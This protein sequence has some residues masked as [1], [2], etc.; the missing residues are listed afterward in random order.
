MATAVI[1]GW[2]SKFAVLICEARQ[3][4]LAEA[5]T[6]GNA[7]RK[8]YALL[9]GAWPV[10]SSIGG[11]IAITEEGCVVCVD[12]D[13]DAVEMVYD[14]NV[15]KL[16]LICASEKIADFRQL[17]PA[18]PAKFYSCP[19]CEGQGFVGTSANPRTLRCGRCLGLGWNARP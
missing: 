9:T 6:P 2:G 3:S 18:K 12:H 7:V 10:D 8:K 5:D 19:E 11:T 16:A 14:R 13:T 15:I 1:D 17:L 4:L